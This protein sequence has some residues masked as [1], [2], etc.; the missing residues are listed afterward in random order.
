[1]SGGTLNREGEHDALHSGQR[2]AALEI[3]PDFSIAV[4]EASKP[5]ALHDREVL[6]RG[7]VRFFVFAYGKVTHGLDR[8]C[9]FRRLLLLN[10][11]LH[12][13]LKAAAQSS[14]GSSNRL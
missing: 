1:L 13:I 10:F 9:F 12:K 8:D 6:D 2:L 14:Q 5:F 3:A 11:N 4:G 7:G